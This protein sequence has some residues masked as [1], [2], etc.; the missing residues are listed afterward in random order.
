MSTG[1]YLPWVLIEEILVKSFG[2]TKSYDTF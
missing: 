2:L 1:D